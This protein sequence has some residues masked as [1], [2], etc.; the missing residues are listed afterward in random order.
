MTSAL[1]RILP[2]DARVWSPIEEYNDI[3]FVLSRKRIIVMGHSHLSVGHAKISL[4][5]N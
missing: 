4:Q 3:I 2:I 1:A 5:T